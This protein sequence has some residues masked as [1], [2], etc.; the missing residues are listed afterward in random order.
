MGNFFDAGRGKACADRKKVPFK[1]ARGW[2][3]IA[4]VKSKA[5]EL[6]ETCER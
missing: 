1:L 3:G 2:D 5:R 6:I 4:A